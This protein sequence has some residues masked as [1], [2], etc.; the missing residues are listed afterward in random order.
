MKNGKA[1]GPDM[2]PVEEWEAL[3]DE[4]MDI[5]YNLMLQI[6]EQEKIPNELRG[7]ILIPIFKGRGYVQ[8]CGDYRGIKLMFHTLKILERMIDTRLREE[9]GIGKERMGFM[10]GRGTTDDIFC[11]RQLM[12]KFREKQ[13]DLHMVLEESEGEDGAREWSQSDELSSASKNAD[14]TSLG[15]VMLKVAA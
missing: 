10:R 12:E 1:T 11:L 14:T 15:G 7:S 13:R 5:L 4:G 8:E 3:G 9:A 6:L 2:I